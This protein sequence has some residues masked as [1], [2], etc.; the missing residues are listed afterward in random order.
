M[1]ST[2]I[3]FDESLSVSVIRLSVM[4]FAALGDFNESSIFFL[5]EIESICGT[6][7]V[8]LTAANYFGNSILHRLLASSGYVIDRIMHKKS[9]V[10]FIF[11]YTL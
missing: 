11:A 10:V 4:F 1:V 5:I 9:S 8:S 3:T 7:T 2:T 6:G